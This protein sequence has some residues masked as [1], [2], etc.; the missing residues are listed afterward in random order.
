MKKQE[1]KP[2]PTGSLLKP[3]K[4]TA[5]EAAALFREAF[6]F[7]EEGYMLVNLA[8]GG[9]LAVNPKA[10]AL[11]GVAE[12]DLAGSP[13][14]DYLDAE[15][16]LGVW[17]TLTNNVGREL[18][19]G[20]YQLKTARETPVPVR[21]FV[22]YIELPAGSAALLIIRD[23]RETAAL[24]QSMD[25]HQKL[26]AFGELAGGIAHQFNNILGGVMSYID[27]AL[28]YDPSPATT[29]KALETTQTALE[30]MAF[31][32][33]NMR[34]Y[35]G[36]PAFETSRLNV[37][38]VLTDALDAMEREFAARH[39]TIERHLSP[40]PLI[41]GDP[42][43][44]KRVFGNIVTNALEAL[45]G[46]G[47]LTVR[48]AAAPGKMVTVEFT[49]TGGGIAPEHLAGVFD[50]FFT[51]KGV[52]NG[53]AK[54]ALGLGLAVSRSIAERHGGRIEVDST[55]DAGSTFRVILPVK[56]SNGSAVF[57]E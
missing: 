5:D 30:R 29:R 18:A 49:D 47:K 51:T 53:G 36:Q 48:A 35:A 41:Q 8:T 6:E 27:F 28:N 7:A 9:I 13:L 2:L 26:A 16:Y 52:F 50:P 43:H 54:Y 19:L 11:V 37:T 31:T 4:L 46:K 22:H 23:N 12:E 24:R 20:Q 32:T 38:Q 25:E 40:L 3:A 39:M 57:I 55:L 33:E 56:H 17:Q 42:A 44:L 21:L 1:H 14:A 45:S 10:Q 34:Y 15:D